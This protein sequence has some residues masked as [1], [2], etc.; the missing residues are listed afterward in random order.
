MRFVALLILCHQILILPCRYRLM[1]FHQASA[2]G[3]P[4]VHPLWYHYPEDTSTYPIDFQFLFGPSILVSL[5]TEENSISA[6]IHLP[7]DTYDFLTLAPVI[8]EGKSATLNN[9]DFTEIPVYTVGGSILPLR[10]NGTMTTTE[11]RKTDF[12]LVVAPGLTVKLPESC[13]LT[14]VFR[15]FKQMEPQL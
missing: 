7:N 1:D 8:G 9:V 10:V 14:M 3:S 2:D 5:V 4:V 12:E 11:L 13:L 15:W 6:N